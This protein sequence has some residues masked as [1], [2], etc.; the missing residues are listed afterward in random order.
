M[1]DKLV[2]MASGAK[3]VSFIELGVGSSKIVPLREDAEGQL[4]TD[5]APSEFTDVDNLPTRTDDDITEVDSQNKSVPFKLKSPKIRV[6]NSSVESL[7]TS[8]QNEMNAFVSPHSENQIA[9]KSTW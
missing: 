8:D 5:T 4:S 6:P 2:G 3:A 7:P 1:D 9:G